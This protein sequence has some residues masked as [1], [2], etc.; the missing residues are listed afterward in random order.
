MESNSMLGEVEDAKI[1]IEKAIEN[2][3][4]EWFFVRR[5]FLDMDFTYRI[6]QFTRGNEK[7][8]RLCFGSGEGKICKYI[9]KLEPSIRALIYLRPKLTDKCVYQLVQLL[10]KNDLPFWFYKSPVYTD[11]K[12]VMA[13]TDFVD[14]EFIQSSIAQKASNL[15]PDSKPIAY[16]LD[17]LFGF[18][19]DE[20]PSSRIFYKPISIEIDLT[21]NHEFL[22]S[23]DE[24]IQKL[25]PVESRY[26]FSIGKNLG[27][28]ITGMFLENP[29]NF[30]FDITWAGDIFKV[31]LLNI[32]GFERKVIQ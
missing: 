21:S 10:E 17:N 29:Y 6:E 20:Y 30:F 5:K 22:E 27:R 26:S 18:F 8:L 2:F 14:F 16:D 19:I 12:G 24:Q 32:A 3:Y 15:K 11:G 31:R 7:Y 25:F 23:L 28:Y 9:G 1:R 4:L 13:L